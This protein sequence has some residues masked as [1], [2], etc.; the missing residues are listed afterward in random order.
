MEV[1]RRKRLKITISISNFVP[2]AHT[3][4]QWEAQD[5]YEVLNEKK[6]YLKHKLRV[7]GISYSYHDSGMSVI[8]A[9]LAR[10]DRRVSAALVK[11]WESGCKFDGWSEH[12]NF[13]RWC[14]AFSEAG[15]DL[16]FYASR[17]RGYEE[18]FPWETIDSLVAKEF[19]ISE[20]EKAKL[21]DTT[22]DCRQG[23]RKCGINMC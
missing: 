10:G 21:A 22:N 16:E 5:S 13:S 15:V 14:S 23:C 18:I 8:E 17:K 1:S 4:F 6:N 20:N 9:V 7:K 11:A 3:P 19:L 2:K 12:F